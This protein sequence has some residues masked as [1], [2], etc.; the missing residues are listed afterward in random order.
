[1]K[2]INNNLTRQDVSTHGGAHTACPKS[3]KENGGN[4]RCCWCFNHKCKPQQ[5]KGCN[6]EFLHECA[7]GIWDGKIH[8]KRATEKGR[9]R[10]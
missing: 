7:K 3:L 2:K 4:F 5:V 10:R 9:I 1:M 6:R 8:F